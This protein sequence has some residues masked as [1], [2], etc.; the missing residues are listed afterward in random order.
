MATGLVLAG[1]LGVVIGTD[2]YQLLVWLLGLAICIVITAGLRRRAWMLM[3]LAWALSGGTLVLPVPFSAR[4][5]AIL[6]AAGAYLGYRALAG[7]PQRRSRHL[8][9]LLVALNVACLVV[10]FVLHPVGFRSIGSD[11]VGGRPYLTAGL[12]AVAA[13]L[14][15]RLPDSPR[16]VAWLPWL[17][18]AGTGLV[19][20][21]QGIGYLFPGAV[22]YLIFFYSGL[23]VGAYLETVTTG[24][25]LRL[26]GLS[27]IGQAL[28]R[29]L[30]SFYRPRALL[31][32]W[33]WRF[34]LVVLA[35]IAVLLSGFRSSLLAMLGTIVI[36]AWLHRG[37]RE[38]AV[39]A[40]LG[41]VLLGGLVGGQGQWYDL[42]YG[43]QRTL[44]FLPGQWSEEVL[45][46][47]TASTEIRLMWW[48]TVI[49]E[50]LISDWWFGD[51][52]G[53][54]RR[55]LETMGRPGR[56]G[57]DIL[58]TGYYHN[59]PLSTIRYAGVIGLVLLYALLIA[60]VVYAL[61]AVARC[62][63][64][65]LQPAAFFVAI[66]AI[67][68][69]VHFTFIYGA[70]QEEI[71]ELFYTAGLVQLLVLMADKL[72]VERP[73]VG[74]LPLGQPRPATATVGVVAKGG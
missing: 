44:S 9:E 58:M 63:G 53:I 18:V 38:L 37:L 20:A 55:D 46:D 21:L 10:T 15:P 56:I 39:G 28:M 69:P 43:V 51:G 5:I 25:A 4:D 26:R 7:S 57:Q 45:Q 11:T 71:P 62:R 24:A 68:R 48:R 60:N 30:C 54:S 27:G 22:P 8:L 61:R 42:P 64:T 17:S 14:L 47:A 72:A 2:R 6:L 67:W 23:D 36:G 49:G 52:F 33:G 70:Y 66:Q 74:T 41:A 16:T 65:P 29:L 73:P 19:A 35:L 13:W 3:P 1:I 12:A 32:P 40:L 50:Q 59:G 31:A 34:L